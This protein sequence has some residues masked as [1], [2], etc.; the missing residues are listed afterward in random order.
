MDFGMPSYNP[1]G[2]SSASSGFKPNPSGL[3]SMDIDSM[4]KD[5][6]EKFKELDRQEEEQK[7]KIWKL[8]LMINYYQ[9]QM[10]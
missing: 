8:N 1:F 3:S 4:L 2:M 5:L 7:K 6:D 9:L 10:K